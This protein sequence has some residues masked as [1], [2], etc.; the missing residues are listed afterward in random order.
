MIDLGLGRGVDATNPSPWVN[1]SSFQVREVTPRNVIGTEESGVLQ[2]YSQEVS[3]VQSMQTSMSASVPVSQQV[4]VGIDAE[5]SRNYSTN[6]RSV[7]KKVITRTISYRADFDDLPRRKSS[8]TLPLSP[9]SRSTDQSGLLSRQTS[10]KKGGGR[11]SMSL[12]HAS[13]YVGDIGLGDEDACLVP[14]FEQRLAKWILER[15]LEEEV[16]EVEEMES[17]DE[18][19]V[20]ALHCFLANWPHESVKE[21][22]QLVAAKCREFVKHFRITHYVS[23]LQLGA[24]E[25]RVMSE[26]DFQMQVGAKGSVGVEKMASVAVEQK[27]GFFKKK[28]SS[29][30]TKIG[31]LHNGRKVRRGTTEEAVVGVK[32]QPISALVCTRVLRNKLQNAIQNYIDGQ[33]DSKGNETYTP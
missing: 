23:S 2:T 9:P 13:S 20:E 7:G 29:E 27:V 22:K 18:D 6:R 1:K 8:P 32:F 11:R 5:L 15:L 28:R 19:P 25:Y 21:L 31:H 14:T 33:E 3:S 10:S 24:S 26:E 4:S 16:E 17:W 12:R 30:A